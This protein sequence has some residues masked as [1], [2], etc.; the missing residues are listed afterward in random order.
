[1]P[2]DAMQSTSD[3]LRDVRTQPAMRHDSSKPYVMHCDHCGVRWNRG[4]EG[5][6]ECWSCGLEPSGPVVTVKTYNVMGT[7]VTTMDT[8]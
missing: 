8:A 2:D 1:M 6:R 3:V 4:A 5:D 7:T